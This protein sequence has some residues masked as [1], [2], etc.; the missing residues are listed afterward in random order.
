[1]EEWIIKWKN[2]TIKEKDYMKIGPYA[3]TISSLMYVMLCPR[4]DICFTVGMMSR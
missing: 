2:K 1:M 3:S 4:L